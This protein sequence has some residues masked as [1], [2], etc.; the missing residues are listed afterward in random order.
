MEVPSDVKMHLV[1]VTLQLT[2]P[3]TQMDKKV[4]VS[5]LL[6]NKCQQMKKIVAKQTNFW[7]HSRE[8]SSVGLLS[9]LS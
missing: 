6:R 4:F 3:D 1:G 5:A 8:S 9:I 2:R 7:Y